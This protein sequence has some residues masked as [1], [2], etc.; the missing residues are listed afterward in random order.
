MAL[1]AIDVAHALFFALPAQAHEVLRAISRLDAARGGRTTVFAWQSAVDELDSLGASSVRAHRTGRAVVCSR[2]AVTTNR[3]TC[4]NLATCA[5]ADARA[6]YT[7]L[8]FL[9]FQLTHIS[10]AFT[11]HAASSAAVGSCRAWRTTPFECARK[12]VLARRRGTAG[13]PDLAG[14]HDLAARERG[15]HCDRQN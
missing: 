2:A 6:G 5:I 13:C 15:E 14:P 3:V 9:V 8:Q 4:A 7:L 12:S 1:R 11:V 10:A